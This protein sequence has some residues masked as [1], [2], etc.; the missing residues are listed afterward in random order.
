MRLENP[1]RTS[2]QQD[3]GK[4]SDTSTHTTLGSGLTWSSSG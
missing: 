2:T 4:K 1:T 3:Q